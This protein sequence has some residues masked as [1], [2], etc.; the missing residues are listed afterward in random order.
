SS[1]TCSCC[2][3]AQAQMPLEI[4]MWTCDKCGTK[5]DRDIN[6]AI[7]IRNEAQRMITAGIVV[8]AKGGTFSRCAGLKSSISRVHLKLEAP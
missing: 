1:K 3:H 6:A 4:R 7:N 8:T 2:L 5:H